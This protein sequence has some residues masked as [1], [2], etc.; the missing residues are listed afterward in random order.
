[1][2]EVYEKHCSQEGEN[3]SSKVNFDGVDLSP[4]IPTIMTQRKFLRKQM[5]SEF[6]ERYR[7]ITLSDST[8]SVKEK[9]TQN[10]K[11]LVVEYYYKNMTEIIGQELER[12]EFC[13]FMTNFRI[14]LDQTKF[15]PLIFSLSPVTCYADTRID[16]QGSKADPN[17]YLK[18]LCVT[19]GLV[20]NE[21]VPGE[22]LSRLWYIP[23]VSEILVAFNQSN[24][25][26]TKGLGFDLKTVIFPNNQVYLKGLKIHGL[27]KDIFYLVAS[28]SNLL[29]SNSRYAS[30]NA[31]GIVIL[32]SGRK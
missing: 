5:V 10:T 32:I 20:S 9:E 27:I 30:T 6:S 24:R 31:N 16:N 4:L 7:E 12:T 3:I 18:Q 29:K 17:S 13:K 8:D 15:G 25:I 22:K 26:V 11:D 19:Q 28:N 2:L 1:M 14:E 21:T 23:H